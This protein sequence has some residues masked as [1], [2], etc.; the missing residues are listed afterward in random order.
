MSAS[1]FGQAAAQAADLVDLNGPEFNPTNCPAWA[2]E[3]KPAWVMP[4]VGYNG[5]PARWRTEKKMLGVPT[6]GIDRYQANQSIFYSAKTAAYLERDYTPLTVGYKPGTLPTYE[7]VAAR[8]TAGCTTEVEKGVALLTRA[9]PAVFRHPGMPP[10]GP[11]VKPDRNLEDEALL[12]TGCGWC[13]E[14]ARVFIR[15]CQVSGIPARMIHLFGQSHTVAEFYAG[16]GW[17]FA[18]ASLF[19][20]APGKGGKLLSTAQC[21]D[22]GA[23]QRAYAEARKK[24][25]QEL[26]KMTDEE[27]GFKDAAAAARYRAAAGKLDVEELAVRDIDFGV[28]NCPLPK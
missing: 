25:T 4:Y 26:L 28:M 17:I 8:Y 5:T 20:V 6:K 21:H 3:T 13:N 9:M 12:A 15:L 7:A 23:G 2:K 19:M 24:R 11:P 1:A 10:L 27:L 18:D 14:Q 22:R 16:G